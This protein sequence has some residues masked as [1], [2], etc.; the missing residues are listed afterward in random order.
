MAG[1]IKSGDLVIFN[2][3]KKLFIAK[4]KVLLG[5]DGQVALVLS[6]IPGGTYMISF[7]PSAQALVDVSLVEKVEAARRKDVVE[8]WFSSYPPA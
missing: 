2:P 6:A 5:R 1:E 7:E 4:Q 8:D 3:F